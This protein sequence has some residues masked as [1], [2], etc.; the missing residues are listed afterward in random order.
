MKLTSQ[1][2]PKPAPKAAV[3]PGEK[4]APKAGEK[5]GGNPGAQTGSGDPTKPDQMEAVGDQL[6]ALLADL[7][8]RGGVWQ[9][10]DVRGAHYTLAVW[11]P[12]LAQTQLVLE[13]D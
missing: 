13:T 5:A 1:W 7:K 8:L 9:T 6:F 12:K 11:W 2:R 10:A 4:L 3:K